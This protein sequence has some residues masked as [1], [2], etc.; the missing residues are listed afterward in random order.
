MESELPQHPSPSFQ[1]PSP[2][3]DANRLLGGQL[4]PAVIVNPLCPGLVGT[5]LSQS[6]EDQSLIYSIVAPV[7]KAVMT[8]SPEVG[9][10][11][12]VE[13][14]MTPPVEHVRI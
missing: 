2:L 5:S 1:S 4:R 13:A 14:V 11:L 8:Q 12:L 7:F 10:R 6:M 3:S 9:S